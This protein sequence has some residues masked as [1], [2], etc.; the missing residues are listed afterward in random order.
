MGWVKGEVP[1][2]P[3]GWVK[4]W[5]PSFKT[6]REPLL[7]AEA[8]FVYEEQDRHVYNELDSP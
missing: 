5:N 4:G 7:G 6:K 1:V 8:A 3:L 2:E